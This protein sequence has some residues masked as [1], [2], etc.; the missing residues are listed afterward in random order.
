MKKRHEQKLV[1][2]SVLILLALNIP[3]L[4]LFDSSKPI[5][6]LPL[7]YLYIFSAWLFSIAITY[8]IIKRY[9]E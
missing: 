6:G 9:Y 3:L 5:F 2:L 7:I 1:I 8:L 4:L